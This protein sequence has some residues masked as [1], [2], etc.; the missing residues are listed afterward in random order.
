M[1][2]KLLVASVGAVVISG[3]VALFLV[4]AA[5]RDALEER[6][7]R[8]QERIE[9]LNSD[10]ESAVQT[11]SSLRDSVFQAQNARR[12]AEDALVLAERAAVEA[13][14]SRREVIYQER[15]VDA[16][17]DQCLAYELPVEFVRQL[18]Q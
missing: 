5:E 1:K 8:A 14:S 9:R 11:N 10:L 18:P 4:Q 7:E 3:L 6:V 13:A 12:E 15:L 16:T 2:I 17:L